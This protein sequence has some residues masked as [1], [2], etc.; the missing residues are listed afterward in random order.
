MLNSNMYTL[1]PNITCIGSRRMVGVQSIT[2]Y[3]PFT[4]KVALFT[5]GLC[6]GIPEPVR[7]NCHV[8]NAG[9]KNWHLVMLETWGKVTS[10]LMEGVYE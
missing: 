9:S 1:V 7:G 6:V 3:C 8:G 2:F 5:V 4:V 10:S